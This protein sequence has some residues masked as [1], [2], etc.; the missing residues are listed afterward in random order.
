MK[1]N[2]MKTHPKKKPANTFR[3]LRQLSPE[4]QKQMAELAKKIDQDEAEDIKAEGR[5]VLGR[6]LEMMDIIAQL[7]AERQ[8]QALSLADISARIGSARENISRMETA[9][10]PNPTLRTLFRYAEALG[11]RIEIKLV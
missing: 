8:R 10:D 2:N 6:Y 11:K 3:S 9:G 4:R 5:R 7:R 1:G